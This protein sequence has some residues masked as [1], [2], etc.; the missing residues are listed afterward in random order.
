MD[1]SFKIQLVFRIDQKYIDTQIIEK[2]KTFFGRV[3][4]GKNQYS[5]VTIYVIFSLP[6]ALKLINHFDTYPLENKKALDYADWKKS[7]FNDEK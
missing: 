7:S 4:V 1:G 3:E 2:I 6:D 5:D